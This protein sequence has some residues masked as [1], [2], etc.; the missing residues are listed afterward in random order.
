MVLDRFDHRLD[1]L[2]LL[3]SDGLFSHLLPQPPHLFLHVVQQPQLNVCHKV[4]KHVRV[5]DRCAVL[6]D[7]LRVCVADDV[8]IL[9][10]TPQQHYDVRPRLADHSL[11]HPLAIPT[12]VKRP[13][14]QNSCREQEVRGHDRATL[15]DAHSS[16]LA[17][18]PI[19]HST[20]SYKRNHQRS[21]ASLGILTSLTTIPRKKKRLLITHGSHTPLL[22]SDGPPR[23]STHSLR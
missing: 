20:H 22:S 3:L 9:V 19:T 4:R 17:A 13:S 11:D 2:L 23:S 1:D 10:V 18:L 21:V 14:S 12:H 7:V 15:V 6:V 16:S 8:A 5:D